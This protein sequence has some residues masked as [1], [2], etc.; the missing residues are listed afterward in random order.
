MLNIKLPNLIYANKKVLD[1]TQ[2][3]KYDEIRRYTASK[4]LSKHNFPNGQYKH[5]K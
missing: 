5:L 1:D 4:F 2:E 3:I